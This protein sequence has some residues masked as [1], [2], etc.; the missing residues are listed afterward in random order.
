MFPTRFAFAAIWPYGIARGEAEYWRPSFARPFS[1]N[2]PARGKFA[3][4]AG[5]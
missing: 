3:V 1:V 2:K 4:L 5:L